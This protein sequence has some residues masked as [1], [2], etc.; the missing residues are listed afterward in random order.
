MSLTPAM[1]RKPNRPLSYGS[2]VI[3]NANTS[4]AP[5]ASAVRKAPSERPHSG[6][7]SEL[8]I[9][10]LIRVP[11]SEFNEQ[12]DHEDTERR[13]DHGLR[14]LGQPRD[15]VLAR[16]QQERAQDASENDQRARD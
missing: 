16:R 6:A 10:E 13:G 2:I 14:T 1:P 5:S 4:A 8:E 3:V 11:I 15:D 7:D 12:R 9:N